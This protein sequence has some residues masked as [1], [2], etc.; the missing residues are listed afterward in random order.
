MV[1]HHDAGAADIDRAFGVLD[2]HDALERELAVPV[3]A[4]F[5][6]SF[7]FIDWSSMV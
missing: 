3:G 5:S 6:A 7:Q 4:E 1:G 2:A